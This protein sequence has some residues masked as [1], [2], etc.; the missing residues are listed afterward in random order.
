[1]GLLDVTAALLAW[2]SK[3]C[4]SFGCEAVAG[5]F[6][7]LGLGLG[8][9]T[10]L[11]AGMKGGATG[12]CTGVQLRSLAGACTGALTVV[13]GAETVGALA[14]ESGTPGTLALVFLQRAALAPCVPSFS[15]VCQV[16][17]PQPALDSDWPLA[18]D[19]P[20]GLDWA[21]RASRVLF[22]SKRKPLRPKAR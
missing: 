6:L 15:A 18:I 22:F 17:R 16:W 3:N 21:L 5:A 8:A 2:A 7:G 13:C 4:R 1:M 10:G 19:S 9:G 11:L 20:I 12:E 14:A